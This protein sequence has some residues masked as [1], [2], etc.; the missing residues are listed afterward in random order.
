MNCWEAVLFGA[1]ESG[2]VPKDKLVEI[3]SANTTN[4]DAI[5]ALNKRRAVHEAKKRAEEWKK[6]HNEDYDATVISDA[7][8]QIAA[9]DTQINELGWEK[10]LENLLIGGTARHFDPTD[11]NSPRPLKG[12]IVIF[13]AIGDHVTLATGNTTGSPEVLSLWSEPNHYNHLQST[14]VNDIL[15]AKNNANTNVLFYRPGWL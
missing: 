1:H 7:A 12:D 5:K 11:P 9:V 14:T 6:G 13:N 15:A 3:Y 2:I 4:A 10:A 8:A